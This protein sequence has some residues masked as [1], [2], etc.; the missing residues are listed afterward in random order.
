MAY[1]EGQSLQ[2]KIVAGPLKLK[3]AI[4]VATQIVGNP[5]FHLI[6]GANL[7][8]T[9]DMQRDTRDQIMGA[10]FKNILNLPV[11]GPQMTATEVMARKDEFIREVGPVFGRFETDYN[12]P[13]AE[14]QFA[15]MLRAGGFA[16]IP[17]VL[18]GEN[19]KF[20]FE[21]P[22]TK[23][24]KQIEAAA[25]LQWVG[26]IIEISS[27]FPPALDLPNIDA[28]ARFSADAKA[29]P[30]DIVNGRDMVAQL[31]KA[32]AEALAKQQQAAN[33]D[34]GLQGVDQMATIAEKA[35]K[36]EQLLGEA[37]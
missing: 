30:H 27:A 37:A 16:P 25:A 5:F 1:V 34:Q 14:R 21:L 4:D 8:I 17:E 24:R 15:V 33:I 32:K 13:M 22:V 7:P 23:I 26:E 28:L 2:E 18:Q 10:F 35:G 6:S 36:A 31:R 29:L 11:Q 20:E 3:E 19:I 9:R 12:Q